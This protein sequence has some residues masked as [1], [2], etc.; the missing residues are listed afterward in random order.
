MPDDTTPEAALKPRMRGRLHQVAFI[1][2]IP[3]G[4]TLVALAR[5]PA[6]RVASAI[7]AFSLIGLYG[8]SAA[9]HLGRWSARWLAWMRRLDHSM[10]F[11]LIA[12]TYTPFAVLVL[13]GAFGV[14]TLA[15]IW[16]G[17]AVGIAVKLWRAEGAHVISGI[18]Y[19][20]LGWAAAAAFPQFIRALSP[21]QFVLILVGGLLYTGGALILALRRP[22]PRPAVFGYHEIWHSMVVSAG[23]CHYIVVLTLAI[24]A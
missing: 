4:L 10:I 9:Y 24:R 15:V 7:Y 21:V 16:A 18:L 1:V 5:S 12:G 11:I 19:I 13:K 20:G 8:S 6:A 23:V 22:N 14:V 17:A 3:A 2:S